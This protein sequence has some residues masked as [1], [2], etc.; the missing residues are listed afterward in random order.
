MIRSSIF[1]LCLLPVLLFSSPLSAD[2]TDV[3]VLQNGDKITGELKGL[4]RGKLEFSTDSMG[5]VFIEWDDIE[6]II[7]STGQSVELSDGQRYYGPL[8]K[9]ENE[10][11]VQINTEQGTV[12]LSTLDVVSMYPVEAGFWDRLDVNVSLGFSWDKASSV[13]RY[14]VGLETEYRDPRFITRASFSTELTTQTERDDTSR[15]VADILHNVF[16]PNKRYV[17]YFGSVESNDEL[18]LD[19][20]ALAGVGYG[21]VPIRSNR[22]WFSL[23][24]GFDVNRER[25][26]DG[27]EETN[28]EAVGMV[29]Y[30][31]YK[32]NDPERRFTTNLV[33]FP[34]LT[35]FGRVRAQFNSDFRLEFLDD[36][37]WIF[38][39]FATY[40]SEPLDGE[41]SNSDYGVTS[42]FA[43]KF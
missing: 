41:A 15:S 26:S 29:S 33:L 2:K 9:A 13:G 32:Y 21:W 18:G 20:R 8:A 30:E 1:L 39:V 12:D 37:F 34:S 23:A 27:V 40:D 24:G 28:V 4:H 38:D 17:T 14:S 16:K 42:S 43:Y 5:T 11:T 35:D 36:L 6:A 19:Y 10:D 3:V 25:S 7:S 22:N 31:Y